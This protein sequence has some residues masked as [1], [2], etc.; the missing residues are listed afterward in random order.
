VR[1][2]FGSIFLCVVLLAAPALAA[3]KSIGKDE[4]NVRSGPSLRESIVFKAPLGYPIEIQKKKGDW[5]YFR[6]WVNNRG[7]V[8]KDLI[9]DVP[10]AVIT[11][12]KANVR[13]GPGTKDSV[14]AEVSEGE[15]YKILKR[16]GQWVEIG[17]YHGSDTVGWIRND[18]VFGE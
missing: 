6:D 15:I 8:H 2:V 7:W 9:S 18:L 16:K 4:V 14:V 10:T 5:V 13:S 11:V 3:T 17:Y 1:L 12:K